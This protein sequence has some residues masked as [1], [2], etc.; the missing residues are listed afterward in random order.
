MKKNHNSR[1]KARKGIAIG[2]AVLAVLVIA[3]ASTYYFTH[4]EQKYKVNSADGKTISLTVAQMKAELDTET[5]Y[6]G[7]S[8]NGVDV[9]GKTL[10][11][12]ETLFADDTELAAPA[13]SITLS[14]QGQD[15]PIDSSVLGLT[16]NIS[17][18]ITNAYAY[19][20]TS[21]QT[22]EAAALVERYNEVQLLKTVPQNF[23]ASYTS[24]AASVSTAV[25]EVLDPLQVEA[26]DAAASSFDKA[27]LTFVIDEEA[28]GLS[29]DT[30]TAVSDVQ[31]AISAKEYTKTITV[32]AQTVQPSITKADLEE[33]LGLVSTT[34]TVTTGDENRNT[35][36]RLVCEIID[37][38]ILQPGESFDY[39]EDVGQRTAER[40]FKEAGGIFDGATRQ[41]LGG[42]ICQVS[43]T[44]FHSVMKADLQV[45]ERYAHQWPSSYVDAGTDATVT[46]GGVNFAFTNNTDY[47][48]AIHAYYKDRK[49]TVALYGRPVS[50]GMTIE[51]EGVVTS[52]TPPGPTEYVADPT[53]PAGTRAA[54]PIRNAHDAIVAECYKVYYKDGAEVKRVKTY[55]SY[56]NAITEKI[57]VGVL[58]PDGVTLYAL[59]P[60]T[61]VVAIPT[62]VPTEAPTE[63]AP[64]TTPA[65]PIAPTV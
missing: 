39:N 1:N 16:N 44:M 59:D 26:R 22:D 53:L 65:A 5:F 23:E 33:T 10:T 30:D 12:V 48:V 38:M 8:I 2:A 34:T 46:W 37:G 6:Q 58:A 64:A 19:G 4:R 27:N 51:I 42:G 36:I 9:S 11:E 62:T 57:G 55:T 60:A 25:H 35:N 29:L 31:A 50:D 7:I 45:D 21:Q 28:E 63:P 43:G 52:D 20:R 54:K 61:G 40:G 15:Y 14:V 13:V 18:M 17:E 24:S 49:V 32:A 47:P 3:G 41:E 56:Y